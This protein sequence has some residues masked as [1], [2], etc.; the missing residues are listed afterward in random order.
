MSKPK[1]GRDYMNEQFADI[2]IKNSIPIIL[3]PVEKDSFGEQL[4]EFAADNSY[5]EK[6]KKIKI[7]DRYAVQIF[8]YRP[9]KHL[10][11][12]LFTQ[13]MSGG[14]LSMDEIIKAT[15][16]AKIIKVPTNE[17]ELK[18][19]EGELVLLKIGDT[20]G[21]DMNPDFIFA[22]Q[23]ADSNM[24]LKI[25]EHIPPKAPK[26]VGRLYDNALLLPEEYNTPSDKIDTFVI[27]SFRIVGRY[28]I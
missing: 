19:K 25:S 23:F 20:V 22:N 27:E 7:D 4:K 26:F 6:F 8:M 10:K 1:L 28:E 2:A 5:K 15:H 9:N 16:V 14:V 11:T 12:S 21:E 24:E 3:S 18:Y 17:Q 13:D